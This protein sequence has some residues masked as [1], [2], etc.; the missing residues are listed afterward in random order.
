MKQ[1]RFVDL[2]AQNDEIRAAVEQAFAEI[3]RDTSYVGGPHVAAFEQEFAHYLGVRHV[4][5]VSSGTDALRL[6]LLALGIGP[7]DEVIMPT[8]TFIGT[9][10]AIVQTGA[11]PAFVDV[12]PDTC[13]ISVAS[14]RRYLERGRFGAPHGPKAIMPVHLYGLPAAMEGLLDVAREYGLQIVED[15]CQAHGATA[16]IHGVRTYA[17]AIGAAGCFSF[18]PGKNLGAW[19][20]AGAV[21]TNDSDIADRVARLRDHGR[22]SHYAHQE[23]GY[24]AR[25]DTLQA[26]VLCAKL[27]RLDHWNAHR[28]EI[29]ATYRELLAD[30]GV[31]L[32]ADPDDVESA[33]HLFVIRSPQR[34][35]LRNA[36]L[37]NGI[38]C[39]IHYPVPLHL[40]PA[41][42]DY[43]Y[44][45]GDF[46]GSEQAADTVLS[47]PMHPHLTN[48]ELARVVEA[49]REGLRH[50]NRLF[51]GGL[52]DTAAVCSPPTRGQ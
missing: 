3:H 13:N 25:L 2:A 17:G 23:C 35:A 26:A 28:R 51:A 46:P 33:Y 4:V 32:P 47:L 38:E 34:D 39:G 12:D 19:G 44:R 45:C 48:P 40:Q 10:E 14:V 15:A 16:S 50:G 37:A 43:G 22:I 29:A 21:A 7:G 8:M 1:V 31:A 36:L 24:N 52:P 30:S 42:R 6:A 9:A 5:G 20:E 49:L 41:F 18:Y 27:A 11:R